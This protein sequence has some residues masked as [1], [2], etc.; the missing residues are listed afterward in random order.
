VTIRG[1]YLYFSFFYLFESVMTNTYQN[2]VTIKSGK[3]GRKAGL[4][5]IAKSI[6]KGTFIQDIVPAKKIRV[7]EWID[8]KLLKSYT[9]EFDCYEMWGC[10]GYL[11]NPIALHVS[12]NKIVF[13]FESG[14][15]APTK[16]YSALCEQGY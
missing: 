13:R 10:K 7:E 12:E 11:E 8:R 16:V 4:A 5:K 15:G 6:Q 14:N 3:R 9:K 1:E 2:L